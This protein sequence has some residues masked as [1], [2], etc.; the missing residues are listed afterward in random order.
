[1]DARSQHPNWYL[2]GFCYEKKQQ[3]K[4]LRNKTNSV[5]DGHYFSAVESWDSHP[6]PGSLRVGISFIDA[7]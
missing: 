1:M 6:C 2:R 3:A 4:Q 7:G 5:A